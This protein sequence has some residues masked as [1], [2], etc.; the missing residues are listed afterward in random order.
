MRRRPLRSASTTSAN[1]AGGHGQ[2]GQN[3]PHSPSM[4]AEQVAENI[5]AK[6]DELANQAAKRMDAFA[7]PG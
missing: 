2:R 4:T 3:E 1:V 7:T 6:I 5:K